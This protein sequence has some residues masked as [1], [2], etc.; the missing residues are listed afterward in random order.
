RGEGSSPTTVTAFVTALVEEWRDARSAR[1]LYFVNTFGE[2]VAIVSDVALK[3][4][5]FNVLDNAYEVSRDWV[6]LVA[7]REGDNLVLS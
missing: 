4:V 7:D 6:E 3:Q 5:I 2:D 1:T